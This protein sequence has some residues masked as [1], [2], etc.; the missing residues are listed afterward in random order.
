VKRLLP[1]LRPARDSPAFRRLLAG[2]LL[3]SLGTSMT[4]FA[5]VLQ[6]WDVS[7]SSLDVGLLGLTFIPVLIIGLLGGSIADVVDRRK[8][9]LLTTAALMAVSAAFAAQAYAGCCT[10]SRWCR[11]CC[12]R[13]APRRAGRSYHV[14]CRPPSSPPPSRSTP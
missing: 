3:S 2:G 8:L 14:S 4:S 5:V 7:H 13:P 9:A 11:P 12:R 10:C 6:I 1:D